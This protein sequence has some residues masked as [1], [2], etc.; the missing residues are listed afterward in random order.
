MDHFL[1]LSFL[2]GALA[3]DDRAGWQSLL[4]QPVFASLLVGLVF[5]EIAAGLIVGLF[6]ELIWMAILP[7]RGMKRPDQVCGAVVG[8]SSACYLIE[9]MGDPRFAFVI[10]LGVF[11]GLIAGEFTTRVSRPLFRL[12]ENKLAHVGTFR[13][14]EGWQPVR[15]LL[16]IHVFATAYIFLVE[17]L[18]VFVCLVI[19]SVFAKWVSNEA[20][21]FMLRTV[22]RWGLIFPAF[23]VASL[24]HVFWHKHQIRFLIMS[25]M[26]VLFI[27][28][29]I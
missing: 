22:E 27:L 29:I 10:S 16:W 11:I 25:S 19:A 14:T 20:G 15:S 3:V 24:L 23:G 18:I 5:G 7:M 12:R 2:G 9:G 17:M 13:N 1:L 6:L 21:A 26:L 4:A 8:A 28:W